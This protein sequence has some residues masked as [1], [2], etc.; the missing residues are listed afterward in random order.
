MNQKIIFD[1]ARSDGDC[2]ED[3]DAISKIAEVIEKVGS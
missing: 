3:K 1:P 2:S